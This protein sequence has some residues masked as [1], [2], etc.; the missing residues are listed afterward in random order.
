MKSIIICI[1]MMQ[2]LFFSSSFLIGST[3]PKLIIKYDNKINKLLKSEPDPINVPS[4]SLNRRNLY[5]K[6][7]SFFI[8]L[9]NS[10]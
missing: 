4:P 7:Q 5:E 3:F 8:S 2:I 10:I 9:F 1:F 6:N